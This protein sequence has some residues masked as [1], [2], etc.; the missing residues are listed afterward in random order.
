MRLVGVLVA[1]GVREVLVEARVPRPLD[2]PPARRVVV[3]GGE[4]E[5]RPAADAVD[6]LHER[7]AER[8]FADDVGAVVI[9]QRARHDLRRARAAAVRH[10]DDRDIGEL[11]VFGRAVILVGVGHAAARVDD[12]LAARHELVDH[13]DGLIERAARIVADVEQ[14]PAHAFR[15][16]RLQRAA[17]IAIRVLA[18]VAQ[19]DVTGARVDHEKRRHGGNG[20]LVAHELDVDH[21]RVT[22][23]PQRNLHRRTARAAQLLHRL[24]G[25]PALR[26]FARDVRDDVALPHALF[27]GRRSLE[28]ELRDDVAVHGADL[29]PDAVVVPFLPLAHLRVLARVEEARVRIERRE[30]AAHRAVHQA[31][32]IDL[33]DVAGFDGAQRGRERLVVIR[34]LVVGEQALAEEPAD[35]RGH[36]DGGHDDGQRAVTSHVRHASR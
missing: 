15:R 30:H 1:H 10:D 24:I 16:E 22:A 3:R 35:Q 21:V 23:P 27:V 31:I 6:G 36:G 7:L 34:H 28:H 26:A 4:R 5:A 20:D 19:L 18:E 12:H 9:L 33:V 32:R 17:Q 2:E 13:L 25:V 14:Q 11:A 29:D 8:R